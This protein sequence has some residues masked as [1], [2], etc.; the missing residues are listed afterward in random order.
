MDGQTWAEPA[1]EAEPP[2]Q[3]NLWDLSGLQSPTS[4]TAPSLSPSPEVRRPHTPGGGKTA[5]V[6]VPSLF[7]IPGELQ[8]RLSPAG[9]AGVSCV[10][11]FLL[12]LHS[13]NH[14]EKKNSRQ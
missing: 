1:V 3:V 2:L 5:P 13:V 10:V 14:R 12:F 9:G 11:L 6:V 7:K 8:G 4:E